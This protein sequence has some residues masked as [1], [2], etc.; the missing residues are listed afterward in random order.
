MNYY[1]KAFKPYINF[2]GRS[3]RKDF[4]YFVLINLIIS[5]ALGMIDGK[6]NLISNLYSLAVF[7]PSLGLGV[8]RLHD[9]SRSGWWVLINLIPIVG[10]I[11]FIVFAATDSTPGTNKYGPNPKGVNTAAPSAPISTPPAP[12][13][14]PASPMA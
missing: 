4:W 2:E 10:W 9:T 6:S 11:V 8:R 13:T 7:L 1:T 12:P 5:I 14:P 3:R